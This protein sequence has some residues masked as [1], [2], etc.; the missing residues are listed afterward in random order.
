MG[1]LSETTGLFLGIMILP[2]V[3]TSYYIRNLESNIA[4][5]LNLQTYMNNIVELPCCE[6]Q[7][8]MHTNIKMC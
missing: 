4:E 8:K 2:F 6:V 5:T 3:I 1:A 7:K